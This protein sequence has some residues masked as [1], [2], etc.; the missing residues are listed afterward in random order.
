M[1]VKIDVKVD[2]GDLIRLTSEMLRQ[3]PYAANTAITR[4]A[5][6]AA[7][8][9]QHEA[10]THLQIRKQFL[11]KR[12][13]VLQYSRVGNLTAVI[14]VDENVKGSPLILGFLEEGQSGE[15]KSLS[16]PDVAIP[17]TGSPARPSFAQKVTPKLL[18]K[19]LS[20]ERHTTAGGATQWKGKQRTFV[21]PGVGI[22]QRVGR[23]PK[24]KRRDKAFIAGGRALEE[25]SSTVMLYRFKPSAHLGTHVRLRD[26]MIEVIDER[27]AAIFT[28]EF[29]R[30][31]QARVSHLRGK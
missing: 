17:L 4:T 6:E 9:A 10:E 25:S 12:I 26:A 24:S 16:G 28:E 30:E 13:R 18:Y 2:D 5:Q 8:A 31:L 3:A 19:R 11:L 27:F 15:K 29:T 14:G 21:I 7:I 1:S 23:A 20:M 22:F